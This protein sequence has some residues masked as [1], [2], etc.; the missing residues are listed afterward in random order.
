MVGR[1]ALETSSA[2]ASRLFYSSRWRTRYHK[3]KV[4]SE[5]QF[6][7]KPHGGSSYFPK[8]AFARGSAGYV[9]VAAALWW[10]CRS[11]PTTKVWEY[12]L[13]IAQQLGI[14]I[15]ETSI[16]RIF[17]SWG[18]SWKKP[19]YVQFAKFTAS[20]IEYYANYLLWIV[21]QNPLKC[22][23]LDEC[24]FASRSLNRQLALGQRGEPVIVVRGT[25]LK[26]SRTMTIL[27][28][29][30]NPV[31]PLFVE[32]KNGKNNQW[33]FFKF[34]LDA[35]ASGYLVPGDVLI[36]DNAKIHH[37]DDTIYVLQEILETLQIS[38]M[39]LPTYSPELNPCE[40]CFAQIKNTFRSL[41]AGIHFEFEL[42][43]AVRSVL[44][45]NLLNYYKKCL[46]VLY[47]YEKR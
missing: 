12:K 35:V 20:N 29:L 46:G 30:S 5:G 13:F 11:S 47:N 8:S 39:F 24:H 37:G 6:H 44:A 7:S 36:L 21:E 40:L 19:A 27:T 43:L 22:K 16:R 17:K 33:D 32:V 4:A 28:D 2:Y 15:S 1:C 14:S 25:S 38:I 10:K 26:G 41:R 23:F 45:S 42:A 3:K 18:W 31:N 9:S 34:V